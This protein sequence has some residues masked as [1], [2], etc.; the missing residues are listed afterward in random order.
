MRQL[1][2]VIFQIYDRA[3]GLPNITQRRYVRAYE[4]HGVCTIY[5]RATHCRVVVQR[6]AEPRVQVE[7][8]LRQSFGWQWRSDADEAG[9]YVV[10]KRR[11]VV[12]GLSY[13]RLT[14]QVPHDAFLEFDLAQSRVEMD[15]VQG[16]L[17]IAPP[18]VG[19]PMTESI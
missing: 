11:R 5:V 9:V 19:S 13:A 7:L 3:R 12:G 14:L 2:P 8:D 18:Q 1:L 15:N 6:I 17:S 10:L 16:R 4:R